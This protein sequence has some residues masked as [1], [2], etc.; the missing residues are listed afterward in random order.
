MAHSRP[1]LLGWMKRIPSLQ[2]WLG[3]VLGGFLLLVV[4]SVCLTFWALDMQKQDA[5]V[6][7]LAGRQ[8]MLIQ[9]MSS[10][11]LEYEQEPEDHLVSSLQ[12]AVSTFEQT[13]SALRN[14]GPVLDSEENTITLPP[15]DDPE[16]IAGLDALTAAWQAFRPQIDRM[17]GQDPPSG[18]AQNIARAAPS[19][20]ALADQMLQAYEK[21]AA[22]KINRVRS[23]QLGFL[24]SGLALLC[25]SWI[26]VR[27][28]MIEPLTRLDAVARRIGE[29]DM[30][31]P[32]QVDG[33]AE[34]RML[35]STMESMRSQL[36]D[37]RSELNQSINMLETRVQQRTRELEALAAVS[38]EI[39]SHLALKDV[40]HSVTEKAQQLMGS[41]VA[42][43]CLLDAPFQALRLQAAAGPEAAV[44]S[45][46]T[47][48][49]AQAGQLLAEKNA[50]PCGTDGCPRFCAI[51][52]PAYTSSHLVAPLQTGGQVIGAL[53]VGSTEPRV[54]HSEAT[55]ALTQ[56]AGVAAV[57]LENARLYEQVEQVTAMEERQRIASDMHDGLLQTLS[58]MR[59]M[60]R[61]S[62]DQIAQGNIPK[63]L[64]TYHQIERAEE[65]AEI[66]IRKAIA[67]LQEDFPLHYSLQEQLAEFV[68][69]RSTA[70]PPVIFTSC[71]AV[72]VALTRQESEQVLRVA[73]EAVL[74][75]QHY[76]QAGQINVV[77]AKETNGWRLSIID[78][79]IGFT[80]GADPQD[81]RA[82]FGLKIMQARASRLKGKITIDSMPGLGTR[83]VLCWP[84]DLTGEK[85][86]E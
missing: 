81:G 23:I 69:E 85:T 33:S 29:G 22:I 37:S 52:N 6:I 46:A 7:N 65:Q 41:E 32:V 83:L 42:L 62:G 75:A 27:A 3:L 48:V 74:N 68:A 17:V 14:G 80:P 66:E 10:L 5:Q 78:D 86:N 11:A 39:I 1:G 53:C 16:V 35:G 9:Q 2:G 30:E 43:L 70:G 55:H 4:I 44:I 20:V 64:E 21:E 77:L 82:H 40:L 61:M 84:E 50:T 34:I 38:Q 26:V 24:V 12:S 8:R 51:L 45:N 57:A 58:F 60:V 79:G 13:Q 25:A 71:V 67:S 76:S 54:I 28:K 36:L 56:L 15:A 31:T 19:L 47:P 73:R 18:T 63:A 59:W 49:C 72:P